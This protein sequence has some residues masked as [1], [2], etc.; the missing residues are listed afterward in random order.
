MLIDRAL[1]VGHYTP[2]N[3]AVGRTKDV[4]KKERRGG[5]HALLL[6]GLLRV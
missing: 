4:L 5:N 6:V 1:A 2:I 3:E